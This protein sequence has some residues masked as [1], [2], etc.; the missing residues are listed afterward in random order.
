MTGTAWTDERIGR[1]KTLWAGGKSA[2]EI[3]LAMDVSRNAVIGK[4]HRLKLTGRPSPIKQQRVITAADVRCEDVVA[5]ASP[6]PR[7]CR[8]LHGDALEHNYCGAPVHTAGSWCEDHRKV[9]FEQK[10]RKSP[11]REAEERERNNLN[12]QLLWGRRK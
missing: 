3:A 8:F 12:R 10:P 6:A 4:V 9:V 1:L 11:Q 5:D 2:N 7:T